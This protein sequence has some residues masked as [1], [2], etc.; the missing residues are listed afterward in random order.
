MNVFVLCK[1]V[2]AYNNIIWNGLLKAK[3]VIGCFDESYRKQATDRMS[4]TL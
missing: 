2:Y 3:Y 4:A 1:N